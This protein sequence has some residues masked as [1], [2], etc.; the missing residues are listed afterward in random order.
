MEIDYLEQN[1][2]NQEEKDKLESKDK[3]SKAVKYS[4]YAQIY[5]VVTQGFLMMIVVAGIGY[6]IGHY[7][8][9]QDT[10]AAILAVIGGLVGLFI[11]I[12]LLFKLKIGGD[13]NGKSK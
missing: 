8:I 10:W 1:N 7:A 3:K 4:E 11:F 2:N 13:K 5:A 12:S 9:G 6:L